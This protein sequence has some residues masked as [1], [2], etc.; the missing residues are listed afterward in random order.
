[1]IETNLYVAA[2]ENVLAGQIMLELRDKNIQTDPLR[3]RSNLQRLSMLLGF[4]L[5]KSLP[6]K[7]VVVNTPLGEKVTKVPAPE[8]VVGTIMRA[9]IPMFN[10]MLEVFN[11]AE[12]FF[13]GAGR[14]AVAEDL[15]GNEFT[16]SLGYL[17]GASLTGKVLILTDPMLATGRSLVESLQT[18]IKTNGSPSHIYIVA[19]IAA[20]TGVDYIHSAFPEAKI[21]TGDLDAGLNE[22]Y[23]IVP[24]LGDAGDLA[25]GKKI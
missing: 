20:K 23:Y 19:A 25:F 13:I 11:Q 14:Q 4:E 15:T 21:F 8:I 10:G 5:G 2:N 12:T 6:H 18:M 7:E 3:F 22:H 16:I 24:G 17:A 1:M 9:G